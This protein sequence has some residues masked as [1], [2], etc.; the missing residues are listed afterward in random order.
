MVFFILIV[1]CFFVRALPRLRLRNAIVSDTYFHLYCAA[2]IREHSFRFPEKLPRV[3]LNHDYTYPFL[4]HY[5]LALFPTRYRLW[6]ERL[7]GA[8][9]DTL[10]LIL[11]FSFVF[12]VSGEGRDPALRNAPIM[13][14]AFFV[15]SPALLRIGSGPRGY[16][17]SP[18]VIGQMLYML[19]LLAAYYAFQTQSFLVLGFSFLAG[20]ALIITA[21]FSTQVLFLFGIWFAFLVSPY[22]FLA[23]A[24][25]FLL[26]VALTKGRAWKVTEGHVRHSIFYGR[27][28]QRVFL[29]PH[30]RTARKYFRSSLANA[31]GAVRFSR[32]SNAL[33]WYYS[34]PYF[35]HLLVTV[36]PQYL[37]IF[38]YISRY[39]R[40]SLLDR[41]LVVWMGAG[42]FWFLLTK[43][44]PFLFLGEGERYLEYG[45]FPSL[46]LMAKFL[47]VRFEPFLVAFLLYSIF[48]TAFFIWQYIG[49]FARID[50]GHE[51][52]E[53]V[54][55]ELN[56]LPEGVIMPIGSLHYQ[57]LYR[58][59]FPV[60]THGG[61][62]D[63]RLLPY[64]EFELIYGNYPYP[65]RCF[66]EIL[67]RYHVSY[68]VTD[69]ISLK[70]YKEEILKEP[71]EFDR[72][73]QILWHLPTLI[74]GKVI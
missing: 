25:S 2:F 54:F 50:Q 11:I 42:F 1:C 68:I 48:S 26:S 24:G 66:C 69:P 38:F 56:R 43:L 33:R 16:N 39:T 63:E 65:S 47:P 4:Y 61:N 18:R 58:C 36:Y 8:I 27:Y 37:L 34:E 29:S 13:V 17:G 44:R 62:I 35:L 20:A 73:I 31:W 72:S 32:F 41:F 51:Q 70:Y 67:T 45:L 5:L 15:F 7:T 74:I 21:K 52:R 10:T 60:L 71:D 64:K 49:T 3:I 46:F 22:Y 40:L 23:L 12:W 55:S 57:A 28:L 59:R 30:V 53:R 19:H 14:S 9:F 6:L